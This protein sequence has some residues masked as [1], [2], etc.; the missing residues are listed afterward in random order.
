MID[1][2]TDYDAE[3]TMIPLDHPWAVDALM[4]LEKN[5]PEDV[6]LGKP[7]CAQFDPH[8]YATRILTSTALFFSFPA[9]AERLVPIGVGADE[10]AE[11]T[12]WTGRFETDRRACRTSDLGRP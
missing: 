12:S 5:V 6:D 2:D 1:V 11:W 3:P 4:K 10:T 7:L 9:H 8:D